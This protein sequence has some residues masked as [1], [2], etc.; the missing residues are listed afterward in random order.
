MDSERVVKHLKKIRR[1]R[2]PA[3]PDFETFH[4]LLETDPDVKD[5]FGTFRGEQFY[6]G[7]IEIRGGNGSITLFG[8]K[9]FIRLM[10]RNAPLFVDGTFKVVPFGTKQLYIILGMINGNSI[11]NRFL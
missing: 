10:P 1:G 2:H 4:H 5:S 8:V 9:Q 11:F 6:Y 7:N 3:C